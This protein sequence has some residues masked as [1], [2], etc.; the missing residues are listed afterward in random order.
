[1]INWNDFEKVEIRAGTVI[2][3]EDFP[4]AKKKRIQTDNR[5][6]RIGDQAFKRADYAAIYQRRFVEPAD[7]CG[8][9]FSAET[10][11]QFF[12]RVSCVGHCSK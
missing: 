5:F 1:M 9:E 12:F 4:E 10:D 6:W 7:H 3:V 2:Q 11:S 8:N